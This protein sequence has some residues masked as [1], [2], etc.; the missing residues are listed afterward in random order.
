MGMQPHRCLFAL[1]LSHYLNASHTLSWEMKLQR[2]G[3]H[4]NVH[5]DILLQNVHIHQLQAIN[6]KI[7]KLVNYNYIINKLKYYNELTKSG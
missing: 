4:Q 3:Q 5:R 1:F 2:Q 7:G 6:H